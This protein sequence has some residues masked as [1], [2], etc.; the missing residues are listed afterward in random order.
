VQ[1]GRDF[2]RHGHAAARQAKHH[3]VGP[4]EPQELRRELTARV[5]PIGEYHIRALA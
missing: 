1:S 3:G 4:C 2:E 5:V